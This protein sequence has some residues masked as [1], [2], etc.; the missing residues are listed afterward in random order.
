MFIRLI[1]RLIKKLLG[2]LGIKYFLHKFQSQFITEFKLQK[3]NK[4]LFLY[5]GSL[6]KHEPQ[7]IDQR[8]VGLP[9]LRR[10]YREISCDLNRRLPLPD[11][12]ADAFQS[13]DVL[14]HLEPE[15]VVNCLN[16]VY[17]VL[18][19][20]G[21]FR[22]SLPDYNSPP[23]QKRSVYNYKGEIL[24]DVALGDKILV[25]GFDSEV[26]SINSSSPGDA[27]LW[28]PTYELVNKYIM[29]SHFANALSCNWLHANIKYGKPI[30]KKIPNINT[31]YVS[32]CPPN[33]MR[34]DGLPVSLIVD[35]IK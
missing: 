30:L 24:G 32:R 34:A 22:L 4:E 14:E 25:D 12:C 31:F 16:E 18:K 8:F 13:Q 33:D 20:E 11:C 28:F 17:R 29:H 7:Y 23:M 3:L 26:Y 9:L 27:H 1:K 15:K 5:H 10:H 35:L 21:L 2:K 6:L 19:K